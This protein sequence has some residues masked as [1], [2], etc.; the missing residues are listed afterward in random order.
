[1][2]T[3]HAGALVL[4]ALLTVG[5]VHAQDSSEP[6]EAGATP[7]TPCLIDDHLSAWLSLETADR[8]IA[9]LET[10]RRE[11]TEKL[12]KHGKTLELMDEGQTVAEGVT[13]TR[14]GVLMTTETGGREVVGETYDQ[15]ETRLA[16]VDKTLRR[17]RT[18][19]AKLEEW[20]HV[21][22]DVRTTD[23]S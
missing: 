8:M 17:R 19:R 7:H 9:S 14:L 18:Q 21:F 1:M 20:L 11:L 16:E 2:T 3:C 23:D 10:E 5:I 22:L 6:S 4:V 15:I 13:L 12:A